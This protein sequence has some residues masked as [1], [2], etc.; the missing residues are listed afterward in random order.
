MSDS[1][2]KVFTPESVLP[3]GIDT[4]IATNPYT[5]ES[6]QVRNGTMAAI[7]NNIVLLNKE[8]DK[9]PAELTQQGHELVKGI[10]ILMPSLR[11]VG[12]FDLFSIYEW[13]A[14]EKQWGRIYAAILYVRRYPEAMD[15]NVRLKLM[16][17]KSR[18]I[19]VPVIEL[20]AELGL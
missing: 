9:S 3:D 13:I 2:N 7:V 10:D 5:G 16:G 17:I 6:G 18:T 12:V 1:T 20:I 19:V 4:T 11:V 15:Q 8:L 14:V